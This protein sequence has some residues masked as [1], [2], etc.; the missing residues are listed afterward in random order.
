MKYLR[1]LPHPVLLAAIIFLIPSLAMP[2]G[3]SAPPRVS[4]NF[5]LDAQYYRSDSLIGA[6]DV[7][8]KMLMNAFTNLLYTQGD[9][10]AGLRFESYLNPIIGYDQRLRGTGMPYRF[11]SYKS[12]DMEITAGNFYE[13][14][15]NGLILRSYEDW[16]LG[17]DNSLDGVR[18]RYRP[19]K[20][21]S[22]KGVYGKQ[23]YFWDQSRGIVRGFDA[24]FSINDLIKP[25]NE[26][27]TRIFAGAGFVSKYQKSEFI[28]QE[29]GFRY[30]L[31]ENVGAFAGR[32]NVSTM[33]FNFTG[34]YAHKLNDPSSINNFIYKPGQSLYLSGTY[35][36]P[37]LSV[38]VSAKHTDNMSFKSRRTEASA[39]LDI[40]FLPP[41]TK[42]HTYKLS[43][44]YPYATQ[45]NGE[46][47]YQGQLIYTIKRRTKL[48]GP[49]GTFITANYSMVHALNS[50][51]VNDTTAIGQKGT[52]GYTAN[53]FDNGD[54]KYF[55]DFN[56][57]ISRRMN[58]NLKISLQYL[59]L[60]YN[61]D[62]IEGHPGEPDVKANIG[63]AD[64]QY[65]LTPTKTLRFE[66][67]HLS[68][69]QDKG[70][71]ASAM[72]E[73]TI[74]PK[75][76]F[77]ISDEFNYGN[78]DEDKRLHYYNASMGYT[79]HSSRIAFTWGR[80]R[81]GIV[82]VGGVCRFVPAS[83]GLMLTITS[84]F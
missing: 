2:Q 10:T 18:V 50:R 24:D 73:Y 46:V 74:A 15:G 79:H 63:I 19:V 26:S 68:T 61:I 9:F 6:P 44:M 49:Y 70:N 80:Q 43:S 5:Q 38:M 69:K 67:Q 1:L 4:G 64:I 54:E 71:W 81:E 58:R 28:Q 55:S 35:F 32:L 16:N 57:E 59:N 27:S 17:I 78:T 36:R 83:T 14:F 13:Q 7:G 42:Q 21:L 33:K 77:S 11:I 8:E 56:I 30:D 41:L 75:W 25:L 66:L 40:N 60:F 76:F 45:P 22:L 47:A 39:A 20:S 12:G 65:K 82:C 53:L 23:R 84:S 51:Q 62:V 37:G 48:G 31:P 52:L 72:V 29:P 34:E 3:S